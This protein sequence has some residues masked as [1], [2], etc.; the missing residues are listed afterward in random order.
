MGVKLSKK[1][2]KQLISRISQ[3][4]GI[5]QYALEAKMTDEQ[6]VEAANNLNV[7]LLI[8]SANH[9]NRYCQA[10]KTATANAKLKEFLDIKNSQLYK[11]GQWLLSSLSKT[12]L[13]RKKSLLENNLVHKEDYNQDISSLK[14]V[15]IEVRNSSSLLTDQSTQKIYELQN[16]IDELLR[17]NNLFK[18]YIVNNQGLQ[19]WKNIEKYLQQ[20]IKTDEAN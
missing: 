1:E 10:E 19:T 16:R 9:F 6:V 5:A 8:K 14:D 17:Q 15:I 13:E 7:F 12:G 3:A 11:A 4:S 18:N 2:R 20:D